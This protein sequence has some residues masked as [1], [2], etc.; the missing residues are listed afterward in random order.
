MSLLINNRK[1]LNAFRQGEHEA[2]SEIYR[3]YADDVLQLFSHGFTEKQKGIFIRGID[4]VNGRLDLLQDVFMKAFAPRARVLYDGLRPYRGYLM[5]IARN[6]LV[7]HWR[8]HSR[9]PLSALSGAVQEVPGT[10]TLSMYAEMNEVDENEESRL[11]WQR[12]LEVSDSFFSKLD[13]KTRRF[14][15]MRFR[16][17][18]PL[19]EV[20]RILKMTR[21]KVRTLEKKLQ[22]NLQKH[23]QREGLLK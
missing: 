6:R 12:C 17:E 21:W 3:E 22:T 16:E 19:L 10:L 13:E 9:D 14:V 18:K 11:H 15:T 8:S 2:L 7:D 23:L 5:T 1:L 20:A 4:D